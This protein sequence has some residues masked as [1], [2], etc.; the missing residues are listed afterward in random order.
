[1]KSALA[2]LLAAGAAAHGHRVAHD[3]TRLVSRLREATKDAS[4]PKEALAAL[5]SIGAQ[6]AGRKYQAL[7]QSIAAGAT[8]N[9][10]V[11]TPFGV[12]TG[13]A[14]AGNGSNAFLGIPY[15]QPPVGPLRWKPPQALN[16]LPSSPY[17]A[18]QYGSVC[19]QGEWVWAIGSP[20]FSEDCLFLNIYAPSAPAPAGGYPVMVFLHGGSW[21]FGSGSFLLYDGTADEDLV[22]DVIIVTIN[23]RLGALGFLAGQPLLDE[24]TDGSVGNYGFQDQRAA[25]QF[26]RSIIPS[27]GGDA[28][29]VMLFGE[30]AGA[31]STTN[32]LVSPRSQGLFQRAAMESGSFTP[33]AA[34]PLN[35]SMSRFAPVATNLGCAN[36]G[37]NAQ[38]LACMRALNYSTILN[39]DTANVPQGVIEW[40]PTIDGVELVGD[41]RDLLAAG[42]IARVPVLMGFNKDEGTLF[43][44]DA[45]DLNATQLPAA[46]ASYIGAA[47]A[48]SVAAQ[49]PPAQYP[50]P[51][52]ALTQMLTDSCMACPATAA[53]KAMAGLGMEVYVYSY[54]HVLALVADIIDAFKPLGCFHGSELVMVYDLTVAL[55]GAG[56]PELAQ[57]FVRYWTNFAINGTPNAAGL[58]YWP[59]FGSSGNVAV[60]DTGAAGPNI[61]ITTS[62]R[63]TQCAFWAQTPIPPTAIFGV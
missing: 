58:P 54:V 10:S 42:K 50:T 1:M 3:R 35:I 11:V 28:N 22:Q 19:P 17:N 53:A 55:W 33:W 4:S 60:I 9:I 57:L 51:W 63:P 26:V 37:T 30:S 5:K 21:V 41:P 20:G 38:V 2:L 15:A 39:A 18:M 16:M 12:V 13:I 44:K 62:V 32:H 29:T 14:G 6:A 23:Y 8:G 56:E 34:Q 27:F 45:Y 24:S 43:N 40:S 52:W 48:P 25:L 61:T 31:G 47:L 7:Q 59:A 36:A 46:I 49:Y